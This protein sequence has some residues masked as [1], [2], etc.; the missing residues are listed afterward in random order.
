MSGI[1][2]SILQAVALFQEGLPIAEQLLTDA[3][4]E[5]S[6]LKATATITFAA[7]AT[8]VAAMDAADTALQ[9]AQPEKGA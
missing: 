7:L 9:G 6:N 8:D 5:W 1:A 2:S 4:A 3:E